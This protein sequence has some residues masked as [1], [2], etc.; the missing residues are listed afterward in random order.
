MHV[1]TFKNQKKTQ[2]GQNTKNT[3]KA[4]QSVTCKRIVQIISKPKSTHD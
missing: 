1:K 4:H 3:K 2:F